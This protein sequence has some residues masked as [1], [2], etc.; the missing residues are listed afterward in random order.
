MTNLDAM[1]SRRGEARTPGTTPS[2]TTSRTS[3]LARMGQRASAA[4][5]QQQP[6]LAQEVTEQSKDTLMPLHKV[7]SRPADTGLR[8]AASSSELALRRPGRGRVARRYASHDSLPP[9]PQ[10]LS[11]G[12]SENSL[13]SSSSSVESQKSLDSRLH[14]A[15]TGA[16]NNYKKKVF[17]SGIPVRIPTSLSGSTESLR[18]NSTS[19]VPESPQHPP[20]QKQADIVAA[21]TQR[22]YPKKKL[23]DNGNDEQSPDAYPDE[24]NSPDSTAVGNP[25]LRLFDLSRRLLAQR[26][27]EVILKAEAE[28][29]TEKD[30]HEA[31]VGTEKSLQPEPIH[32]FITSE[33]F[34]PSVC[35]HQCGLGRAG[36]PPDL[37]ACPQHEEAAAARSSLSRSVSVELPPCCDD[38]C[39][40]DDSL[41]GS[42]NTETVSPE[43][44]KPCLWKVVHLHSGQDFLGHDL[45][46]TDVNCNPSAMPAEDNWEVN[47][48]IGDD[49]DLENSSVNFKITNSNEN[50][51]PETLFN[52]LPLSSEESEPSRPPSSDDNNSCPSPV[53]SEAASSGSDSSGDDFVYFLQAPEDPG[54]SARRLYTI[55][56]NS[57]H[58]DLSES[59]EP[60]PSPPLRLPHGDVLTN[61]N[62][63]DNETIHLD[64]PR[65]QSSNFSLEN[66][67]TKYSTPNNSMPFPLNITAPSSQHVQNHTSK[68]FYPEFTK[69]VTSVTSTRA[70]TVLTSSLSAPR[71]SITS[72]N[73]EP[74]SST[75]TPSTSP[76]L[77]KKSSESN[78]TDPAEQLLYPRSAI[79]PPRNDPLYCPFVP[80]SSPTLVS[81]S[82]DSIHE[83]DVTKS[84]N[85]PTNPIDIHSLNKTLDKMNEKSNS[86]SPNLINLNTPSPDLMKFSQPDLTLHQTVENPKQN[87]NSLSPPQSVAK[88]HNQPTFCPQDNEVLHFLRTKSNNC[89]PSMEI[90]WAKNTFSAPVNVWPVT[91]HA[92]SAAQAFPVSQAPHCPNVEAKQS[93]PQFVAPTSTFSSTRTSTGAVPHTWHEDLKQASVVHPQYPTASTADSSFRESRQPV[94]STTPERTPGNVNIPWADPRQ[95]Q[96]LNVSVLP[97]RAPNQGAC[98]VPQRSTH[99]GDQVPASSASEDSITFVFVG[100]ARKHAPPVLLELVRRSVGGRGLQRSVSLDSATRAL[101]RL[102]PQRRRG[103]VLRGACSVDTLVPEETHAFLEPARRE[104]RGGPSASYRRRR[105]DFS[106]SDSEMRSTDDDFDDSPPPELP[107]TT[108]QT[109]PADKAQPW[110]DMKSLILGQQPRPQTSP[111]PPPAPR[112][113]TVGKKAVSWSDVSGCGLLSSPSSHSLPSPTSIAGS[114][115][116][117]IKK[118]SLA[119]VPQSPSSSPPLKFP[120]NRSQ[121][122][123]TARR[124]GLRLDL[125]A[126]PPWGTK[127]DAN[128]L[129]PDYHSRAE[130]RRLSPDFPPREE[131]EWCRERSMSAP[132]SPY[133]EP[134]GYA[135]LREERSSSTNS[136]ECCR[137]ASVS[138][139]STPIWGSPADVHRFC[140]SRSPPRCGSEARCR[141]LGD[142]SELGRDAESLRM[143][144]AQ[145]NTLLHSLSDLSRFLEQQPQHQRSK[146]RAVQTESDDHKCCTCSKSSTPKTDET[147]R[148]DPVRMRPTCRGRTEP[149][150]IQNHPHCCHNVVPQHCCC[151]PGHSWY[152]PSPLERQLEASCARLEA[153]LQRPSEWQNLCGDDTLRPRESRL[154]TAPSGPASW[155]APL[156]LPSRSPRPPHFSPRAYMRHLLGVRRRIIQASRASPEFNCDQ[157]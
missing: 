154:P 79:S 35:L 57:E 155:H 50:V 21:V 53:S 18:R 120:Q 75:L 96:F 82:Q 23:H 60:S 119:P 83:Q 87:L 2:P 22:L 31:A 106:P 36:A 123:D 20:K 153:S 15:V 125:R 65:T 151:C 109:I 143:F 13:A 34:L 132:S 110:L 80:L 19:S 97:G 30:T 129:S 139:P 81:R 16:T 59:L 146:E 122:Q 112:P 107:R 1:R 56:E 44:E 144:L 105:R 131:T 135:R 91:Q 104:H 124:D 127:F 94:R 24:L 115:K 71:T 51:E 39:F 111:S 26:Q 3:Q 108:G 88:Q 38:E 70:Q 126:S 28:T 147:K 145:A 148:P 140:R 74:I 118:S 27:K 46:K 45:S 90:E 10:Q 14:R 77:I 84:L 47:V 99:G 6:E 42:R 49:S 142:V 8:R 66:I 134:W 78:V 33:V 69:D 157:D 76:Q 101:A 113:R 73:C 86:T 43:V 12:G 116:P 89:S 32:A 114:P 7:Q 62:I 17:K 102:G 121:D 37:L 9:E 149:I 4:S 141:S 130:S 11:P 67:F 41:E 48:M 100:P 136:S 85:V 72:A 117:I 103:D 61:K 128:R 54:A 150:P 5:R 68:S 29:Q 55:A 25:R 52:G 92:V 58:S 63:N 40:S 95:R 156:V 152:E 93:A 137:G 133:R 64:S 98:S 138:A